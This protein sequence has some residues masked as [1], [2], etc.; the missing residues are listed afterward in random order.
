M[1]AAD[2]AVVVERLLARLGEASAVAIMLS[3]LF[4]TAPMQGGTSYAI[5]SSACQGL[6]ITA[7]R[8]ASDL[9]DAH[10]VGRYAE[11]RRVER[12]RSVV[13]K[14]GHGVTGTCAMLWRRGRISLVPGSLTN[15][16]EA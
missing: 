12:A 4:E 3:D 11:G 14:S 7:G 13:Q 2:R 6:R 16:G 10:H 1:T 5:P 15:R 8:L 9:G